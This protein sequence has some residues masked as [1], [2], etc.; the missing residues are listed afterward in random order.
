MPGCPFDRGS[1]SLGTLLRHGLSDAAIAKGAGP[2]G[3][4]VLNLPFDI[5]SAC[6]EMDDERT[7]LKNQLASALAHVSI[8]NEKIASM[9]ESK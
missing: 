6:A 2:L 4:Q 7:F 3:Y 8:T 1:W 5:E 9:L